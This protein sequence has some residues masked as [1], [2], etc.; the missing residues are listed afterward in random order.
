ML[1]LILFAIDFSALP[2]F[3]ISMYVQNLRNYC[4]IDI[5]VTRKEKRMK[6]S[7][8]KNP[9]NVLSIKSL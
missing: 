2:E 4:K 7:D 3:L 9:I 1:F 6:Y 8:F 5:S